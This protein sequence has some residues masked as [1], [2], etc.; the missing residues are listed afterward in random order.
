[1]SVTVLVCLHHCGSAVVVVV[2]E[3][4]SELVSEWGTLV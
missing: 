4:Y 2:V 3:D 1:M